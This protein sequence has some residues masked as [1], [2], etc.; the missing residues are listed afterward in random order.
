MV[1]ICLCNMSCHGFDHTLCYMPPN[2]CVTGAASGAA[3]GSDVG[4]RRGADRGRLALADIVSSVRLTTNEASGDEP[5]LSASTL[6]ECSAAGATLHS[7]RIKNGSSLFLEWGAPLASGRTIV[8][9]LVVTGE[10]SLCLRMWFPRDK[11]PI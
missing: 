5:G 10:K 9:F 11:R 2:D 8:K 6:E 7:A 4:E 1:H 3:S